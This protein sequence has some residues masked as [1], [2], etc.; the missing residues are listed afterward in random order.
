M[1]QSLICKMTKHSVVRKRVWHD[2]LDFRTNCT[3]CGAGLIREQSGWREFEPEF[4]T[5]L[6]REGHPRHKEITS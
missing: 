4:D 3:R 6:R 2:Q 5:D 1:F